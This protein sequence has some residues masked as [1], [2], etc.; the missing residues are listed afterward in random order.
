[1]EREEE[2]IRDAGNIADQHITGAPETGSFITDEPPTAGTPSHGS[3]NA[4][5]NAVRGNRP[6][7]TD[8]VIPEDDQA[9]E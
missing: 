9:A 4:G 2:I 7:F 6:D 8:D 5:I 1:M 3:S